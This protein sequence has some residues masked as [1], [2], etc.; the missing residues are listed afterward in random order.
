MYCWPVRFTVALFALTIGPNSALAQTPPGLSFS[1]QARAEQVGPNH[2][3]LSGNVEGALEREQLK[4]AADQIDYYTD[5][6]RLI[7]TGHVV[8]IT[9]GSH[10]SADKADLDTR[11]RT[12]IYY[13]AF[14]TASVSTGSNAAAGGAAGAG[15]Q[16][17]LFA[18]QDPIAYFYGETIER[19]G[20]DTYKITRGGFTTC[21]QPTPRWEAV[22]STATMK[23]DRYAVLKNAV[24]KVKNV[25]L[26]YLPVMYYPIPRDDRATGFLMPVWGHSDYRGQSVSNAFFWA[27]DRS[28]D[29]TFVHDWMPSAGQ[30]YGAEYRMIAGPGTDSQV[31]LYRL[32]ERP[33]ADR[34]AHSSFDMKAHA[35][36]RLP[37]KLSAKV[38]VDYF[39]DVTIQ[40]AYQQDLYNATRQTRSYGG[41]LSGAWGR[42]SISAIFQR[43][44]YFSGDTLDRTSGAR[45]RLSYRRSPT[46]IAGLP[47]YFATST[48]F[49]SLMQAEGVGSDRE[50]EYSLSRYDITP[51]IQFPFAKWPFLNVQ[52]SL[53][54]HNT[55]YTERYGAKG[56]PTDDP[57]YRRYLL[58][59]SR[60]V[61]PIF[62]KVFDGGGS[63]GAGSGTRYKHVIEPEVTIS[64]TTSFDH[65]EI[66]MLESNDFVYGGTTS[67]TYGVT[68]RLLAKRGGGGRPAGA[69]ASSAVS[70][71]TSGAS[72]RATSGAQ[73]LLSVQLSQS[74]Y[75]NEDASTVD[76]TYGGSYLGR[77][78]D[79]FSPIALAVR[80]S[81][82]QAFGATLRLEY[83]AG[84]DQFETISADGNVRIT[85][86]LRTGGSYS[87]VK[88]GL[89][90]PGEPEA[91]F[92]TYLG[93]QTTVGSPD[94]KFGGGY[95]FQMNA[96]SR[97]MT[98][99]RLGVQ[100]NAQCCGVAFEYQTVDLPP[101]VR[102][103][104]TQDRR[105]NLSFTLAGIGSFSNF[106]GAFGIGQGAMG[107]G[108]RRN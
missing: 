108:G 104:I 34:D 92:T 65:S 45:P 80:A 24:L 106:L 71:A 99:Q 30:G 46:Q 56:Q 100:Y 25:P 74:Y 69:A 103:G 70:G 58:L 68:Q 89:T 61:G 52:S 66:I 3:R 27:I 21:V 96:A 54:W 5:T 60:I 53:E 95:S 64:R 1:S 48:E 14:G 101:Y 72:S 84:R 37:A 16:S 32:N 90:A 15:S 19:T 75:S 40:Q 36:A 11:N 41:N 18:G 7:A 91:P 38:N 87:Q 20:P 2:F 97:D 50:V 105:F 82:S 79:H 85:S 8:V 73:D 81:P 93:T 44:D 51:S 63:T 10:I 98:Q 47:I 83:H 49:A 12:G 33:T 88:Y 62:S 6:R 9:P 77:A 4:F 59:K 42:D 22:T 102:P 39:T 86:W 17:A 31:R 76:G 23:V 57:L 78:P 94:G 26:L 35:I 67:V 107:M 13:N 43:A 55:Y 29:M 28:Q